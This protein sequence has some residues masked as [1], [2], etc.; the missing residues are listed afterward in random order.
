M[1]RRRAGFTLIELLVVIAII[2][3]LIGLL[4]PAVQKV[5]GAAARI[6]CANNLKQIGLAMHNHMDTNDG[7]PPNGVFTWNGSAVVQTSP[8][9]AI[10]RILPFVEQ[11]NLFRNIDLTKPYSQQ[12]FVTSRRVATYICP[13]EVNDKGSG[14]DPIYGN[15]NWTLNY[16][17]N[18][19]TWA[20]LT[21]KAAG[22]QGGDGAFSPNV[23]FRPADFTD[24][25]SNTI[26][27]SEVKGYTPRVF[28]SPNTAT[29]SPPLAPPAGPGAPPFGEPFGL[30]AF[31]PTRFTHVEWVDGKVHETGFTTAFSP[32]TVVPMDSGGRTYDVDFVSATEASTGD[33]YAAVTSRSFHAGGVNVLL[34]DGS[35]RFVRSAIS[36]ATWQALGTRAGGEVLGNDF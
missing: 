16:A 24:G 1:A 36:M 8:W 35:V 2:A 6:K 3:I 26:G 31:D 33:T 22:M 5:R 21:R 7:L 30:A 15:K 13:S 18:L 32:N 19:G 28:G 11:E 25:M 20:V 12:P 14:T 34:M 9:S 29:F 17:V 4:L 27:M 23:G 10:A